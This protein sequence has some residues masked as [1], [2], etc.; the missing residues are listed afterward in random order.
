MNTLKRTLNMH[1]I[2]F[3]TAA[4]QKLDNFIPPFTRKKEDMEIKDVVQDNVLP[5]F[6]AKSLLRFRSSSNGLLLCQG[7][8]GNGSYYICNPAN[9]DWKELHEP[10]YYD[11]SEPAFVLAFEPSVLNMEAHYQLICAVA[12]LSQPIVYSELYSSETRSWR[13]SATIFVELGDLS[14]TVLAFDLKNELHGIISLPS[15]PPPG[16]VLAEIREELCYIN[17]SNYSSNEYSI[18]IYGGA[19]MSL[20]HRIDVRLEPVPKV[21]QGYRVLPSVQGDV[22]MI[23]V[24]NS[25]YS[26]SLSDQ[27]IEDKQGRS[28]FFG[29]N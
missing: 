12:L 27:R 8:T 14:F 9:K 20:R 25:I 21:I 15:E 4:Y 7:R 2:N 13:R 5:F 19:D 23:L 16:A 26:Y 6:P 28:R 1:N 24:G 10:E 29:Y 3:R 22:V 17:I 11:G 18:K